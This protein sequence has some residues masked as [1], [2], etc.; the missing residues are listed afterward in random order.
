MSAGEERGRRRAAVGI[1][2]PHRPL[3]HR[4]LDPVRDGSGYPILEGNATVVYRAGTEARGDQAGGIEY[5]AEENAAHATLD[6]R[7]TAYF[8]SRGVVTAH[9]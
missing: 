8:K 2:D 5:A 4:P 1:E 9:P 6:E 3:R 7:N